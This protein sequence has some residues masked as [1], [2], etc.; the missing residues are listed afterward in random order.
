VF[1]EEAVPLR[2]YKNAVPTVR[3]D[4]STSAQGLRDLMSQ[5]R[6]MNHAS[7]AE[8]AVQFSHPE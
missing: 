1:Q 5:V 4:N 3:A 6:W 2:R 7:F 8:D